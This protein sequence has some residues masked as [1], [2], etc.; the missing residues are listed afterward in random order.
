MCAGG[1]GPMVRSRKGSSLYNLINQAGIEQVEK[2]GSL[3][4][5]SYRR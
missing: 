4:K 5:E 2:R 3:I 1:Q